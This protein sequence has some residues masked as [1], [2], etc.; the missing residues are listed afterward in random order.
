MRELVDYVLEN[1]ERGA[2]TCGRCI[3][4]PENPE[5]KQPEGHTADLVFFKVS[6][7]PEASADRLR[8][9]VKANVKGSHCDVDLFDG[10]EHSYLEIGAWIGDQGVAMTLMGLGSL[11]GLWDLLTP[12]T[13]LP[14][15]ILT[16][17]MVRQMA[18]Q[19]Y[20]TVKAE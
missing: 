3:D 5:E 12:R 13:M 10:E 18:G 20:M 16:D 8:E 17:A 15:G 1:A 9:L 19:G 4:A 2:C 7:K 11:L 14:P 6:A